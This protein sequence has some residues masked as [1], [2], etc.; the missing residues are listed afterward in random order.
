MENNKTKL[1]IVAGQPGVG[2]STRLI[3]DGINTILNHKSVYVMTP[4]HTAKQN[5]QAE[6][7]RQMGTE[8]SATRNKALKELKYAIHVLYGY[9]RQQVILIDEISMVSVPVLFQLFYHTQYVNGAEIIGYGDAKQLPVIQGNSMIEELLRANIEGNVWDWVKGAYE[10]VDF[11]ELDAPVS[12]HLEYPVSFEVMLENHRLSSTRFNGF[13]D[14]FIQAHIDETIYRKDGNYSEVLVN[15]VRANT[16]MITATHKRGK[17]INDTLSAYF[18]EDDWKM[19]APFVKKPD[20]TKV[21]LNPEHHDFEGIKQAFKFMNV[22]PDKAKVADYKPTAYIVVNVAQGATVNNTLYYMGN[23]P[24]PIGKMQHHYSFNNLY[25]AMTRAKY[26]TQLVGD[27]KSFETM[28]NIVPVSA[29]QRLGHFKADIAL[30]KLFDNLYARRIGVLTDEEVYALYLTTFNELVDDSL[31]KAG[32]LTDYNIDSQPYTFNEMRLHF[33][34]WDAMEMIRQHG[35]HNYDD[36]HKR[37][38]LELQS[39]NAIGNKNAKGKGKVQIW[40]SGLTAD[41]AEV[42]KQDAEDLSRSKFKSKYNMDKRAVVKALQE[43][44]AK[45]QA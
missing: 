31:P 44:E 15:A 32:E 1:K 28:L 37:Y 45:Q 40:L 39:V 13:D 16:L 10:N 33:K 3:E 41:E 29:Q 6:I 36:I 21:Y 30:K 35:N 34:E 17:E 25:T 8:L 14:E 7:D 38:L 20:E 5:L 12:W 42:V 26:V 22:L 18:G 23:T 9:Q 11:D 43:L 4:T 2:K 27:K 24:L 19:Y